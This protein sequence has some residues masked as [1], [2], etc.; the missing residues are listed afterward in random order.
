[1]RSR[2]AKTVL[3]L[4]IATLA[5]LSAPRAQGLRAQGQ[6][7]ARAMLGGEFELR[8]ELFPPDLVM[9]H[10]AEIGLSD[11]QKST[12]VREMQA[13]QSDLVPL[14]FE[15][16]EAG[17]QLRAALAGPRIDE[18]KAASL[19]DRL[20]SLESRIKKRHLALMIRVKNTLTEE[21]QARLKDLRE[22]DAEARRD[23]RNAAKP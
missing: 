4:V 5:G 23:R 10:Q 9:R 18:S 3:I 11:E 12:L 19:A 6:R 1:M 21:Q 16:S 8:R 22:E 20:M 7:A 17:E 13:L 15:I 2:A 14:Q